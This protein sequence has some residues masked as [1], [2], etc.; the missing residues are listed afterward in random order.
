MGCG[1]SRLL[2]AAGAGD[3]SSVRFWL[4]PGCTAVD[5]TDPK[6]FT[7]L[8]VAARGGHL[9][10]VKTLIAEGARLDAAAHDGRTALTIA[11]NGGHVSVLQ[12]LLKA[13][14]RT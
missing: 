11:A 6:G 4:G 13:G 8:M 14:A 5:T 3:E 2:S 7:A 12:A 10:T 9:L 1:S